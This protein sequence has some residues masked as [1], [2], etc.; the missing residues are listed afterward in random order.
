[1]QKFIEFNTYKARYILPWDVSTI[2]HTISVKKIHADQL[3]FDNN[4]QKKQLSRDLFL[5]ATKDTLDARQGQNHI[6]P[7]AVIAR[8]LM[9]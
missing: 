5:L 7:L 1:M 4:N 9:N 3:C 2:L 6:S 8:K